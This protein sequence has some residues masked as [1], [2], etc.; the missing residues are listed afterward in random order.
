MKTFSTTFLCLLLATLFMGEARGKD[1]T[2]YVNPNIGVTHSRWF[3]Y[4]PA[5]MPF[6]LAKLG[7][8]TNGTYGNNQ[9]WEAV[10]YQDDHRSIDGFPCLHEFQVGGIS[11]MPVTGEVKTVPGRVENPAEGFRSAFDKQS[12][13]A[14]PVYYSVYLSDY[15]VKAELTATKRVGLQRYT[16]PE[17]RD[18]HILFNIG[19]RQG[20]S[21]QVVDAFI[22]QVSAHEIE[23]YVITKPEYVKK[24][25]PEATVPMYF[26]AWVSKAPRAVSVFHQGDQLRSSSSIQ[27][28]GAIMSLDYDTHEGEQ[29]VVKLGLSYTSIAN[30]RLNY[31]QEALRMGF[32]KARAN[33]FKTWNSYLGRIDVTDRSEANLTK[34]YTGLY[35]VLLG[36]GLASDVNGAY[37]KNDGTI[38]RIETGRD[39]R[40]LYNHYNT[41][42]M[43][44]GYWNLTP[45][46]ALAY[47]DYYNDFVNS[48]LLMYKDAGWLGDG[49]A[50]SKYVSGV[51]RSE[52]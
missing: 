20:E 23:G 48:Q 13:I 47:P 15:K 19:N 7:P 6:G 40:P 39:G 3:F 24:Y 25:Q 29:I 26:H 43:W 46:W 14:K 8:S 10:G 35:H 42:A 21:G 51:G 17:S 27:G 33:A 4:T 22:K 34:F 52:E 12:E 45:L 38:G 28:A 36:R 2:R 49:I 16:F 30:A 18:A 37:P 1:F 11:L 44:G 50:A 31:E 5:A 9:G 32:D 41:D